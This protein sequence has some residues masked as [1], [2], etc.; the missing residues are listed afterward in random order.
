LGLGRR[1]EEAGRRKR[2]T[3]SNSSFMMMDYVLAS[4][5]GQLLLRSAVRG[6]EWEEGRGACEASCCGDPTGKG[7]VVSMRSISQVGENLYF[8][9]TIAQSH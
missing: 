2:L 8:N 9:E 6:K 5:L 1:K 7:T 4:G 3:Q